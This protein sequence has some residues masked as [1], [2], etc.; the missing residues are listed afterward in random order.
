M[1]WKLCSVVS[2]PIESRLYR[3]LGQFSAGSVSPLIGRP[4]TKTT[5]QLQ[6]FEF[7][8]E[9]TLQRSRMSSAAEQL[10][11]VHTDLLRPEPCEQRATGGARRSAVAA[12]PCTAVSGQDKPSADSGGCGASTAASSPTA[13]ASRRGIQTRPTSAA[14]AD[15]RA[16][17]AGAAWR[18]T[19]RAAAPS[20]STAAPPLGRCEDPRQRRADSDPPSEGHRGNL[21]S[22]GRARDASAPPLPDADKEN[23]R[24]LSGAGGQAPFAP[25]GK[26]APFK[27]GEP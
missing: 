5:L 19:A 17:L 12:L 23:S 1:S 22:V 14:V 8:Y 10:I 27:P 9:V 21:R 24:T 7:A 2:R 20:G 3:R 6:R 15:C 16:L 13:A 4:L 26:E 11:Q 25:A 18:Q